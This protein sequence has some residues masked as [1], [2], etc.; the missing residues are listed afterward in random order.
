MW[1]KEENVWNLCS[2]FFVG[3]LNGIFQILFV[4]HR[5]LQLLIG[6][7]QHHLQFLHLENRRSFLE[8]RPPAAAAAEGGS[9][10]DL[11]SCLGLLSLNGLKL[12]LVV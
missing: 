6:L 8:T 2:S 1:T 10:S 3:C 9:D 4:R 12:L 11:I 7:P 5:P